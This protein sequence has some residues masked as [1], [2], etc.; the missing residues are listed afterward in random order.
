MEELRPFTS[1]GA[2]LSNGADPLLT[3]KLRSSVSTVSQRVNS[4]RTSFS[5]VRRIINNPVLE[6]CSGTALLS[7]WD[8]VETEFNETLRSSQK[9]AQKGATMIE[10]FLSTI[11]P[12]LMSDRDVVEKQRELKEYQVT[13]DHGNEHASVF[14]NNLRCIS[15]RILEFETK[16]G[17]HS[18]DTRSDLFNQIKDL[19]SEISALSLSID[20]TKGEI[21]LL[22]N[23]HWLACSDATSKPYEAE[24][25]LKEL[26]KDIDENSR[27]IK[28]RKN[29]SQK[30]Q[31]SEAQVSKHT[32]IRDETD[33]L[34]VVWT[35]IRDDINLVVDRLGNCGNIN[36][37]EA[38]K[39]GFDKLGV[40]YVYLMRS[41]RAYSFALAT[42][43]RSPKVSTSVWRWLFE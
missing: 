8:E 40:Q 39:R 27:R 19:E 5:A 11:M 14:A 31:S 43:D 4:A 29:A 32:E 20:E 7:E 42:P 10:D 36:S 13:L 1:I 26:K 16:W 23:Q 37:F 21:S 12:Y 15:K 24:R 2:Y 41:L 25:M 34:L 30:Q 17:L 6:I 3:R 9:V 28:S 35:L 38:Y 18:K 22:K 33:G